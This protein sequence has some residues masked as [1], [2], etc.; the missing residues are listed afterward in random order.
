[1]QRPAAGAHRLPVQQFL[2]SRLPA[3]RWG[4]QVQLVCALRSASVAVVQLVCVVCKLSTAVVQL[5]CAVCSPSQRIQSV[6]GSR[7]ARQC[8]A[9]QSVLCGPWSATGRTRRRTAQARPGC[10]MA[11]LPPLL[12]GARR[13]RAGRAASAAA[14]QRLANSNT[15]TFS[16][17][18]ANPSLKRSANGGQPCRASSATVPP[19]S[20]A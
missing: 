9:W 7:F 5:V 13:P 11:Q 16:T 10:R 2:P 15:V 3:V 14:S 18:R 20:P 4:E 8:C 17:V 19:L 1:M 6:C 12:C